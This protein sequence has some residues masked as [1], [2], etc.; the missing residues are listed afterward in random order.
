MHEFARKFRRYRLISYRSD[1]FRTQPGSFS[2]YSVGNILAVGREAGFDSTVNHQRSVRYGA[3]TPF[4]NPY[5]FSRSFEI[6]QHRESQVAHTGARDDG[7]ELAFAHLSSDGRQ[8]F[9]T[10]FTIHGGGKQ[11]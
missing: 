5:R 2:G 1:I 6:E 3:P 4:G 8:S 11:V 10:R 9:V 7:F